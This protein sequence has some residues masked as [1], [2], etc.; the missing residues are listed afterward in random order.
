MYRVLVIDDDRDFNKLVCNALA[1]EGLTPIPVYNGFD[2]LEKMDTISIIILDLKLNDGLD[3]CK[4]LPKLRAANPDASIIIV[5]GLDQSADELQ[6]LLNGGAT[7]F[8]T[9]GP[10]IVPELLELVDKKIQIHKDREKEL[11]FAAAAY[12][13]ERA[14]AIT[15]TALEETQKAAQVIIDMGNLNGV[16]VDSYVSTKSGSKG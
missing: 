8:M 5:T 12:R 4:L 2:A 13:V 3:G 15:K 11:R 10:L 7:G 1:R 9:K 16:M 6:K 14:F